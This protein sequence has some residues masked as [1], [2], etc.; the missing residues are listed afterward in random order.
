MTYKSAYRDN[1][2]DFQ[3]ADIEYEEDARKQN[4]PIEFR[5]TAPNVTVDTAG[6]FATHEIIGGSTVRQK[7]GEEPIE[8][9]IEGICTEPTAI[10]IDGLRDAKFGTIYSDRMVGGS[11]NVHFAS[12]STSPLEDGGAVAISDEHGEFLYEFN[13]STVEVTVSTSEDVGGSSISG[14][15]TSGSTTSFEVQ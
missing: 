2:V 7:T 13:L 14:S 11:L 15:E 3:I 1:H 8:V 4:D 6:R 12:A 10:K 9:E 5:Y